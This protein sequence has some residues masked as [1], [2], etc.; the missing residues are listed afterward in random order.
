[1][2]L[3]AYL[4]LAA[5]W[6]RGSR[7]SS[8]RKPPNAAGHEIAEARALLP[9]LITNLKREARANRLTDSE[10]DAELE[11]WRNEEKSNESERPLN[12]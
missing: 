11:G 3:T 4:G 2:T 9:T 12:Q 5:G 10:I 7:A 1:V 8:N 6:R